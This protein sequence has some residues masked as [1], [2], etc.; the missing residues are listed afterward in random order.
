LQLKNLLSLYSKY[1]TPNK[2]YNP[3]FNLEKI[4][5]SFFTT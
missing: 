4:K 1:R 5:L 3:K 2:F